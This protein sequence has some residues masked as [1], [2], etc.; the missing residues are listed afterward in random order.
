MSERYEDFISEAFIGPIRSVLM[1]DDDYPTFDEVLN[2]QI[3]RNSGHESSTDKEWIYRPERLLG[4][5]DKFRRHKPP[6]L[7]DVHDGQNVEQ[8]SEES[9]AAHLHQSD[10][11]ILDYQLDR[12]REDGTKAIEILRHLITNDH[13]NLVVVYTNTKLDTA[14]NEMLLGLLGPIYPASPIGADEEIAEVLESAEDKYSG[15]YQHLKN[16]IGIAQYLFSRL[17]PDKFQRIMIK[18]RQPY[19]QFSVICERAGIHAKYRRRILDLFLIEF[20]QSERSRMNL[21]GTNG[22]LIWSSGAVKWFKGDSIFVAFSDKSKDDDLLSQLHV[23]LCDWDPN[24]SR[25][26]LAKI[27]AAMDEY[28]AVGQTQALRHVHALASWYVKLMKSGESERRSLIAESVSRHSDQLMDEI[29][30]SVETFANRLVRADSESG[31]LDERC[32]HHFKVDPS[33]DKDQ[34]RAALE[35]N[36]LV[37]SRNPSGWHLTTGHVFLMCGEYWLC[38]SAACDMV[39]AQLPPWRRESYGERLPFIAVRLHKKNAMPEDVQSNRYLFLRIEDS[40]RIFSFNPSG[41]G[42]SKPHWDLLLADKAGEFSSSGYELSIWKTE[43][44]GDLSKKGANGSPALVVRNH[45]A[46]VVSQLRYEYAL[47]L[48]QKLGVSLTRVGLDFAS[49]IETK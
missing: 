46:V 43:R 35:H 16:S 10:L 29:L 30:P 7:V 45:K 37:S 27:R 42:E 32:L 23:A 11:L 4:I 44:E 18:E 5:I 19:T 31:N 3:A 8:Q 2:S 17:R 49:G 47:N 26:F 12:S 21:G 33:N 28:G 25:L 22:P 39:P 34:E 13:F 14:F 1:V 9:V 48:S 15:V 20:E 38:L 24:P 6:L 36:A 41:K 40:V